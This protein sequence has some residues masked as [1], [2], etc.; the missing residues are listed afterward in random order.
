MAFKRPSLA[1]LHARLTANIDSRTDGQPRLRRSPFN[2]F[3]T[4]MAGGMHEMYG[5]QAYKA[6]QLLPDSADEAHFG[7]L[8]SIEGT[9]RNPFEY[10]I[11]QCEVTGTNGAVIEAGKTLKRADAVEYTVDDEVTIVGGEAV[12]SVTAVLPGAEANAIA[13]VAL[14]F[15][16]TLAGINGQ[17]I[18]DADGINNGTDIEQLE[19]WRQRHIENIQQPAQGGA[20]HDYIRWSK[21]VP[22]VTRAWQY[23]GEMG[24]GT[25]TVRFVRD[26]D[27]SIIPDAT[28]VEAVY[29]YIFEQH[30]VTA[31]IYVVA[32][33]PVALDLTIALT[34]NTTV[35]K[36]AVESEIADLLSREAIPEDGN[37]KGT[38]KVSHIREAI[39]I[40]A[41]ETDHVLV[42]PTE[43]VTLT[44]GQILVPGDITWQ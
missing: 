29:D 37:G 31:G 26:N 25:V 27:D 5:Y 24:E 30:P 32:P 19:S 15:V 4:V 28:E 33:I 9:E 13:G 2:I 10:A 34:P 12:I 40:A 17:A 38:I 22:G 6:K 3:A 36:A 21:Q 20:A 8:A 1:E 11:G 43:D 35:V 23:P 41:G 14:T 44:L 42:S 18:V 16:D 7:R 39:S